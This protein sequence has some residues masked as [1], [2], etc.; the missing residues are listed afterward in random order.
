[1][2]SVDRR[3]SG[4]VAR[5]IFSKARASASESVARR[6]P[7]VGRVLPVAGVRL[8][9]RSEQKQ[10]DCNE[11]R[12]HRVGGS[13]RST[14]GHGVLA[15]E[16]GHRASDATDQERDGQENEPDEASGSS[17]EAVAERLHRTVPSFQVREFV[18]DDRLQ[19]G[20][21]EEPKQRAVDHHV[22]VASTAEG[23]RVRPRQQRDREPWRLDA[24][25][26]GQGVDPTVERRHLAGR[27][28]DGIGSVPDPRRT[29]PVAGVAHAEREADDDHDR[30]H[31]VG[32]LCSEEKEG[33]VG[34]VPEREV[35]EERDGGHR[36]EAG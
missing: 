6:R 15:P 28:S 26:L 9:D 5:S 12:H 23:E 4:L 19:F 8:Y 11:T 34:G 29:D 14:D 3:P 27:G 7:F 22:A 32:S 18:G 25:T 10:A 24:D 20:R 21:G 31:G 36:D 30:R 16:Q 33:S 2:I 1:M 35:D 17:D 13:N